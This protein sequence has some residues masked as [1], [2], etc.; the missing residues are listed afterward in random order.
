MG[1]ELTAI[2]KDS[3]QPARQAP[4]PAPSPRPPAEASYLQ[5][6]VLSTAPLVVGVSGEIDMAS[7]PRLRDE[8]LGAIRRHGEFAQVI[9]D[10]AGATKGGISDQ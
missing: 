2:R 3:P 10:A 1:N 4:M 9:E 7:A 5:V 6:D 8:L